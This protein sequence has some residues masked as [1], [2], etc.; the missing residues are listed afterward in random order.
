M[1]AM[2]RMILWL[3]VLGAMAGTAPASA[4]FLGANPRLGESLL[5]TGIEQVAALETGTEL[6]SFCC[7]KTLSSFAR[8]DLD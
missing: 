6:V 4:A 5:N 1:D 3:S 2:K 8:A 7:G